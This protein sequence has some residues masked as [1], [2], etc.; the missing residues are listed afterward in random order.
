MEYIFILIVLLVAA[1]V[2]KKLSA[3]VEKIKEKSH[4]ALQS[5]RRKFDRKNQ[6]LTAALEGGY[7]KQSLLNTNEKKIFHIANR[8]IKLNK[9]GLYCFPQVSC[10]EIFTHPDKSVFLKTVNSKRVDFCIT[11]KKFSPLA[12]IEYQ[13]SGHKISGDSGYRDATKSQAALDADIKFIQLFNGEKW[14]EKLATELAKLSMQRE[15][16]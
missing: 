2:I 12:V 6:Q 15:T 11:D 16:D 10:G 9:Q 4:A 5:E 1:I 14:E 7:G 3:D 8:V 13:G